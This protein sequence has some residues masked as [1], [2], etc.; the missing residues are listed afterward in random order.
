MSTRRPF[1]A[2][3]KAAIVLSH[4]KDQKPVSQ[5][6]A[7]HE[8]KPNMFYRWQAEFLSNAAAAFHKPNTR[9]LKKEQRKIEQLEEQLQEKDGI[10]AFVTAE[11]MCS[12]KK[13][14][15]N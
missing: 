2:A 5:V 7:E 11:L 15:A 6:C 12:K 9:Q 14:G 10:I 8:I 1:S 3:E 13:N 4:L